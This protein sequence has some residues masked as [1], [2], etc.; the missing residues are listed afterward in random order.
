[1]D[2]AEVEPTAAEDGSYH[3]GAETGAEKTPGRGF[4]MENRSAGEEKRKVSAAAIQ[5]E[6]TW[7]V[8]TAWTTQRRVGEA[9]GEDG[10]KGQT[11]RTWKSRRMA[12]ANSTPRRG[13]V[14]G[15]TQRRGWFLGRGGGRGGRVGAGVGAG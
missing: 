6:L 3:G 5:E 7:E 10:E 4:S 8:S 1:M 9:K 12:E 11:T 14:R 15:E 13:G 2:T